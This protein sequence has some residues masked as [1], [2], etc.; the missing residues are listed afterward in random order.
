MK[1]IEEKLISTSMNLILKKC[2]F[3]VQ[4]LYIKMAR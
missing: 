4:K 1:N 2:E 3:G